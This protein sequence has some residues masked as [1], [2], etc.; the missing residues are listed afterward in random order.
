MSVVGAASATSKLTGS[1]RPA[2]VSNGKVYVGAV[3]FPVPTPVVLNGTIDQLPAAFVT[4]TQQLTPPPPPPS[5]ASPDPVVATSQNLPYTVNIVPVTANHAVALPGIQSADFAQSPPTAAYPD[6][7]WLVF[8]GRTN[9]LHNFTTSS[10]T[11]FPPDFQNQ[12][13]FVINPVNW[14][15][16]SVPWSQSGVPLAMSNSLS[17]ADQEF[18]QR[19]DTLYTVGGYSVPDT[20]DVTGNTTANSTTVTVVDATG[21]AIGQYVSGPG[22]PLFDQ[23]SNPLQVTITAIQGNTITLSQPATATASGVALTASTENFITYDTLSALSVSGVIRAVM[24]GGDVATQGDIRQISDPRL[25]VT[26][27]DMDILNG[28]TYLV[29]GQAFQGGYIPFTTSPPSFTQIYSDEIQSFRI[30]NNGTR[31][32]INWAS[33]KALRDPINFRR[34][35]GNMGRVIEPNGQP[36]L[37]YYGGVFSPGN[38]DTAY[39]AP[40]LIGANGQPRVKDSYQQFFS[41]YTTTNISLFDSRSR[42]MNTLFL[43]GIS[44]YYYLNGQLTLNAPGI[45]GPSWVNNVTALIQSANGAD[46]EYSLPPLSGFYGAYSAFFAS[47]QLPTYRNGVIKLA[48]L[49]QPTLLGYM[50][51]GIYSTV[52]QTSDNSGVEATQT[53]A[54]N[55]V[56]EVMLVPGPKK[57][58]AKL[59]RPR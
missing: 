44:D 11:N 43:G 23:N 9:G 56:F 12:D 36:G 35:D 53:G 39:W 55:Q 32:A 17:S 26:G 21:L 15:T 47:S 13:I 49:R 5:A 24:N 19:G 48:R 31:L 16:W 38:Q 29:F 14:Q 50:Y 34:R 8:G 52:A 30:I 54:S 27:G 18:Y 42:A 59:S 25:A 6:G 37:T 46:Q 57:T 51:G 22:I 3:T 58:A 20:V 1:F 10:V 40:I 7:L 28:R 45:P 4:V 33:Y 41:Q 2:K